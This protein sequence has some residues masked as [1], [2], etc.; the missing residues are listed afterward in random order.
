ME[1]LNKINSP[2]DIKALDLKELPRLCDELRQYIID[3]VSVNPGHLG[4]SI[5]AVELAVA[6]HYVFDTPNDK[7]VWDV[8]H[9]AYPHKILTGRKELFKMNRKR[10]GISGFPKMSESVYDSFG[11]GHSSTSI[12]AI[13]GMSE[14]SKLKGENT[15]N[16]IAVIGDASIGGGMAFEALNHA[17]DIGSNIIVILNDNGIAIDSSVGAMS[18]YLTSVATSPT[19]NRLKN[20]LW[21]MLEGDSRK[22]SRT[23]G[24]F[25][26]IRQG[27]KSV[28]IWR[29]NLF[30][31][32]GFRYY[33]PTDGHNVIKLVNTLKQIKEH[34]GPK[35]FHVITKKG[36]GLE[37]AEKN[38]TTYH[39]PGIFSKETGEI[40]KI[41][42]TKPQPPKYQTV[43]GET[44]L[45]LARMN[46][47]IVGITPAMLSGCSLNIMQ[48]EMPE[49][50]FDVGIAEQHAVTFAAGLSVNGMLPFC[51]IYSTFTQR[52]Y[53]Q[54]I[55]DVALQNLN[56]V[57][58][59][60]RAGIVGED[61]ATHQGAFD[62]SFMRLI[63]NVIIAAPM[64]EIELRN[65]L[66][67][68][69]LP[70]KGFISIRYPRGSGVTI[71][72]KKPF[73]EIE[74]GK[75]ELVKDGNDIAILSIGNAG[76]FA[77]EAAKIA[78]FEGISVAVYNM[79]FLKPLDETLLCE[80]FRRFDN[81]ITVEDGSV[82]GGLG[83][84]VAEFK[85]QNKF[86]TNVFMMGIPDR[87]I[88]QGNPNELYTECGYDSQSIINQIKMIYKTINTDN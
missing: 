83:G 42:N 88:E 14:A 40:E 15:S 80:V 64:N 13:V 43:F 5:G 81:I 52:A 10:N 30:E 51:N 56:F 66:Y 77:M 50:V 44:V 58:C 67:T 35:L 75:G 36:K 37:Q 38:P 46:S 45:E 68:A 84:A 62:L 53:D 16:F 87:F 12:S 9:Q 60:D 57:L 3:E 48:K 26:A 49:R 59:M 25:R 2:S 39:A 79:R 29:S 69:Q 24:A 61:G 74:I 72:W 55:H 19:Y 82:V 70:N 18:E 73:R 78:D 54:I 1:L 31:S 27:I 17:G 65:M 34:N 85:V 33:G 63:P 20:R 4:S 76:N 23:I 41:S 32:M 21:N 7:L 71:D 28:I 8:G 86:N 47:K 6:I 11:V 22:D